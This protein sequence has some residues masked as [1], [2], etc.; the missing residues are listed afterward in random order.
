MAQT[1]RRTAARN[2]TTARR[3]VTKKNGNAIKAKANGGSQRAL[4]D[5]LSL[6]LKFT[7][8]SAVF[9]QKEA[10]RLSD[11]MWGTTVRPATVLRKL[12]SEAIG[13]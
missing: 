13:A 7:G 4:K 3:R 1:A 12:V 10:I 8:P 6:T 2:K 9:L 5:S 11:E